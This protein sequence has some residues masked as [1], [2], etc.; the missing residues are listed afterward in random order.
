MLVAIVVERPEPTGEH[1]Q[2]LC[3][4]KGYD[5]PTRRQAAAEHSCISHFHRIGEKSWKSG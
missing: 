5:N 2:H 3:L 4:D 1:P